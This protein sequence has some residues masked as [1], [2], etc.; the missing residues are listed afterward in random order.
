MLYAFSN[1]ESPVCQVVLP[2]QA[3]RPR[4]QSLKNIY[5]YDT[6]R[7]RMIIVCLFDKFGRKKACLRARLGIFLIDFTIQSPKVWKADIFESKMLLRGGGQKSG[8]KG[9]FLFKRL[10]ICC[11]QIF[12]RNFLKDLTNAGTSKSSK[13]LQVV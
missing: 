4:V 13:D 1:G 8:K 9:H 12:L 2:H 3:G 6:W 10:L 7:F 11:G 5:K